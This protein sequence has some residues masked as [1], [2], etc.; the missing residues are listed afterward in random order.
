MATPDVL[1]RVTWN[2]EECAE[3]FSLESEL[4]ALA[5]RFETF[6]STAAELVSASDVETVL[7]RITARAALAV[8]A[9]RHLLAVRPTAES[10]LA[11]HHQGLPRWRGRERGVRAHGR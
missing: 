11:I 4:A 5:G 9:P 2:S 8:R 7:A 1:F 6:Q 10:E 3:G